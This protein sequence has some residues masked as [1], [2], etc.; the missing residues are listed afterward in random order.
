MDFPTTHCR[1]SWH[2][3]QR[4][5]VYNIIL[6]YNLHYISMLKENLQLHKVIFDSSCKN[7][8]RSNCEEN[9]NKQKYI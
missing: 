6:V 4:D 8:Y 5:G 1:H 9:E 2:Q 7:I 3:R